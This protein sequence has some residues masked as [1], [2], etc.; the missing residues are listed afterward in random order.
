MVY[1]AAVEG[2]TDGVLSGYRELPEGDVEP[3]KRVLADAETLAELKPRGIGRSAMAWTDELAGAWLRRADLHG[4]LVAGGVFHPTLAGTDAAGCA[5]CSF[6]RAC[7][8]D[9]P[10]AAAVCSG[11][12]PASAWPAPL[13]VSKAQA[14]DTTDDGEDA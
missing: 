8:L 1:A 14:E 13:E 11:D 5:H 10:R 12:S 7:R 9:L 2:G 3:R 6:R 4:Q